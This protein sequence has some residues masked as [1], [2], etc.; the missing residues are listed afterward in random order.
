VLVI[1]EEPVDDS[2]NAAKDIELLLITATVLVVIEAPGAMLEDPVNDSENAAK[3]IELLLITA[4]VLVVI[5][6]LA[7]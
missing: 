6:G 5:L 2:E 3:D 1:N 7:A 4:A